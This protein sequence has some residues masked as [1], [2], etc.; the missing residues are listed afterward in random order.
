MKF[1]G[2]RVIPEQVELT[3]LLEEH[4]ARYFFAREF[5]QGQRVL[6]LG[7]GT[8]YGSYYLSQ[9]GAQFVLATDIDAEAIQYA[10]LHYKAPNLAYFQS[11]G[12]HLPLSQQTFNIIV[13]FEVIEHL[14][15][16]E[17][18]LT[19]I[20]RVMTDNGWLI[21][22]TPNKLIY[23][24]GAN[25]S[26]NPFHWREYDPSELDSLLKQFFNS[27]F[28]LGQRPF[29]GFVIGP[30]PINQNETAPVVEFLPENIRT[31][32]SIA[33]SKY[34]VYLASKLND[35]NDGIQRHLVS[36]YYLGQPASYH[37]MLTI[38]YIRGLEKDHLKIQ[39]DYHKLE[40]LVKGYQAGKYIRFMRILHQWRSRI[41]GSRS[42]LIIPGDK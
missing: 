28:I 36:N 37:D 31:E 33:D 39:K 29:Y 5:V 34:L 35:Q 42:R 1:T 14:Q 32:H 22:S 8:G 2:E 15:A 3:P 26:H 11:N 30:V 17:A 4:L 41:F 24:M 40:T 7:C 9:K 21:G 12:S 23:S 25:E 13:S 19:E 16:V 10:R 20:S 18:Y 6:D 38:A 27:V